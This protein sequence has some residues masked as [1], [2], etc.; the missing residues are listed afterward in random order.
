M[1]AAA[2]TPRFTVTRGL[3]RCALIYP[4]DQ[5]EALEERMVGMET[6]EKAVRDFYRI[7][8]RWAYPADLDEHGWIAV[9][10][11]SASTLSCT[12]RSLFSAHTTTSSCGTRRD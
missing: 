5:R 1:R 10:S 8:M 11:N 9:P 4:N 7:V 2:D 12:T 3:E 6:G